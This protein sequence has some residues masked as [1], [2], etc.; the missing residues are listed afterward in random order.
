[1][2]AGPCSSLG[3]AN[4]L[5]PANLSRQTLGISSPPES[6]G[7]PMAQECK[8]SEGGRGRCAPGLDSP[9]L[10]PGCGT[11]RG[12]LT[13]SASTAI[14][15]SVGGSRS[16]GLPRAVNSQRPR[17]SQAGSPSQGWIRR[18]GAAGQFVP[19]LAGAK[20]RPLRAHSKGR[21]ARVG[22]LHRWARGA[23]LVTRRLRGA[24]REREL[25][26]APS[27]R[28]ARTPRGRRQPP[29]QPLPDKSHAR[30]IGAPAQGGSSPAGES[31]P[32]VR[33]CRLAVRPRR[34]WRFR[35]P[36]SPRLQIDER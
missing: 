19:R 20:R 16:P 23:G 34:D 26:Y 29:P 15:M 1:M 12:A 13:T 36:S 18:L 27:T 32:S 9:W 33:L 28:C 35:R 4:P 10:P 8:L 25:R 3:A 31:E 14:R 24:L 22:A 2:R 17:S 21:A 7:L 5:L 30:I 6:I 11:L